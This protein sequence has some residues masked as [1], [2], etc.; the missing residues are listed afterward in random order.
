MSGLLRVGDSLA[1]LRH[2]ELSACDHISSYDTLVP[3][4]SEHP[5][6]LSL[7][8]TFHPK[9]A[10][11]APFCE[12]LPRTLAVLGFVRFERP[13]GVTTVFGRCS[14][15]HL[16]LAATGRDW[17][18]PRM[19]EALRASG[20]GLTTLS[21]PSEVSEELCAHIAEGCPR[22]EFLCRMRVGPVPFGAGALSSAFEP[23]DGSQGTVARRRGS[24]AELAHNG[25][26]WAP[27]TEDLQG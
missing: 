5:R 14:L 18:S 15:E 12:A 2:L 16:W 11:G 24:T 20:G 1:R 27:R 21:L 3:L 4:F 25:A 17:F 23:L 9:A 6:L 22:L 8:A 13:E 19:A 7:R 26:L 10:A